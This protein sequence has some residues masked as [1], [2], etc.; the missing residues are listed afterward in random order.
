MQSKNFG[1]EKNKEK[2]RKI[3]N[4]KNKRKGS[5][6]HSI[7]KDKLVIMMQDNLKSTKIINIKK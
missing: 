3:K 6:R 2:C 1:F 5:Y 7:R 4:V